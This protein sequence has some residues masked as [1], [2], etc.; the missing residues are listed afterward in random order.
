[1]AGLFFKKNGIASRIIHL[2]E[3]FL[4]TLKKI[5]KSIFDTY[6]SFKCY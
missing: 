1:M 4:W 2:V 6:K 3:A 5:G